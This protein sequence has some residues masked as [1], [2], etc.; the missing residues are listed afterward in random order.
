[1]K[2]KANLLKKDGKGKEKGL[3][4]PNKAKGWHNGTQEERKP[5]KKGKKAWN[6]KMRNKNPRQKMRN[7]ICF[8]MKKR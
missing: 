3:E 2:E 6:V 8:L 1:M 4:L 7:V 5:A